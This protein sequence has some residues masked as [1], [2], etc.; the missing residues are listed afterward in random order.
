MKATS[1]LAAALAAYTASAETV[2][3]VNSF[4]GSETSSGMAYYDNN[5]SSANQARPQDYTDVVNGINVHWEGATVKGTFSSGV[6]FTSNIVADAN[7]KEINQW[8]GSGSNG[9]KDFTCWKAGSPRGKP[10]LL[11]KVDGWEVYP[12]YFCRNNN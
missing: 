12:I 4:K 6:T 7:N 5:H 9:L 10:F 3:L 8:A 11:Y 1:L 2:Y